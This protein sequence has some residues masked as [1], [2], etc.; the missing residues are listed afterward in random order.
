M[1]QTKERNST[2][3]FLTALEVLRDNVSEMI[4]HCKNELKPWD[5]AEANKFLDSH[6]PLDEALD[7]FDDALKIATDA[8]NEFVAAENLALDYL[9]INDSKVKVRGR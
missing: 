1:K 9:L 3:M 5:E 7:S 2:R 6:A 4:A 8:R